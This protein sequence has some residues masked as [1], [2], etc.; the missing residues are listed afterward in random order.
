MSEQTTTTTTTEEEA[1]AAE[2]QA[3]R[4]RKRR[5]RQKI[6]S[7]K[8]HITN[9]QEA[10]DSLKE[11]IAK[12]D[13]ELRIAETK[14]K[15]TIYR[16][17]AIIIGQF[18]IKN[19][20]CGFLK[21]HFP[22]DKRI[23]DYALKDMPDYRDLVKGHENKSDPGLDKE[24][25]QIEHCIGHLTQR[26]EKFRS[27]D[28][29]KDKEESAKRFI[30]N[31]SVTQEEIERGPA[32]MDYYRDFYNDSQIE[33]EGDL[34]EE[35]RTMRDFPDKIIIRQQKGKAIEILEIVKEDPRKIQGDELS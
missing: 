19:L 4:E 26:T 2:E 31:G 30:Q 16:E 14:T 7:N 1:A 23:I 5:E 18:T 10:F 32:T 21:Q 3:I 6:I 25:R 15:S 35:I 11:E 9:I 22:N 29:N 34:I 12:V 33:L 28:D 8:D 24:N 20:V 13:S 17:Y 27:D